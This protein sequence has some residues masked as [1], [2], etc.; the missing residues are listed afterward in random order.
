MRIVSAAFVTLLL[1]A[2]FVS[3]QKEKSFE[4]GAPAVGS[5][6]SDNTGDCLPKTAVGAYIAGTALS[7]SNYMEVEVDV[8][9]PGSYSIRTDTINGYSFSGM[10]NFDKSGINRIRLSA[11]GTPT[12]A[13]QDNFTVIFD[14][15]FCFVPVTVLPEGST[16]G[17]ATFTLQGAGDSCMV[18]TLSGDYSQNVPLTGSNTVRIKINAST[19]GTYTVT[20]DTVNGIYFSGSGTLG[21]VGEQDITLTGSGTPSAEGTFTFTVAAG[22][23]SCTFKV[24]VAASTAT[25]P[26]GAL[27]PL[28]DNSYWTYAVSGA[29]VE[30]SLVVTNKGA[31]SQGGVNYSFFQTT[32]GNQ[33]PLDTGYY[34]KNGSDYLVYGPVDR[35]TSQRF[36][37]E[38]DGE[39]LFLKEGSVTNDTWNSSEY[40]GTINNN[41][42]KLQ[43]VFTCA[44][45]DGNATVNNAIS[46]NHV[47]RVVA[48]PQTSQGGSAYAST[49]EEIESYYAAGVG[50]IY[51]KATLNGTTVYETGILH[52]QVF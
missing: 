51:Q 41:P 38:V 10:G 26:V 15:S 7:D 11:S 46:Y 6:R 12:T 40:S 44:G 8:A 50:L 2:V 45:A 29:N 48:R 3:C 31:V 36:D 33:Q 32:D 18:S 22:G 17:P 49:G 30:D 25:P 43:Y 13:G 27:F 34:R 37:S 4:V 35:F 39:I 21:S 24:N 42:V 1:F 52:Y 47:W 23:T 5:L 20:T 16:S 9:S 19:P 14:T 28:T